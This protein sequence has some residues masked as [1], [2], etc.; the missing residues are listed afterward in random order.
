LVNSFQRRLNKVLK[1]YKSYFK[2]AKNADTPYLSSAIFALSRTFAATKLAQFSVFLPLKLVISFCRKGIL[3]L[4]VIDVGSRMSDVGCR[5][6]DQ[7]VEIIY[8][9]LMT[10]NPGLGI[11]AVS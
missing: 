4:A 3:V 11:L 7:G 10:G 8:E 2:T 9:I 1:V 5:M 6:S